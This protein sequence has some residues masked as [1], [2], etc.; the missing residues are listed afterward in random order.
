MKNERLVQLRKEKGITQ[1]QLAEVAGITQPTVA[2]IE[3]GG[4]DPSTKVKIKIA[5]Y[6]NVSVE[7]LFFEVLYDY[8]SS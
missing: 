6:L 1:Q 2:Y 4:I 8:K 7:W 3:N 5:Q